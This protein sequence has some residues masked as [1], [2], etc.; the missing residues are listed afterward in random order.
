MCL[1]LGTLLLRTLLAGI[2]PC[3]LPI[4]LLFLFFSA[5]SFPLSLSGVASIEEFQTRLAAY[6]EKNPTIQVVAVVC[7][8]GCCCFVCACLMLSCFSLIFL[9]P[10]SLYS[11]LDCFFLHFYILC[12]SYCSTLLYSVLI[13]N[14]SQLSPPCLR[15]YSV[16]VFVVSHS[17]HTH[18]QTQTDRHIHT[19]TQRETHTDTHTYTYIHTG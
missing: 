14:L 9:L 15:K 7:F 10:F 6:A 4:S 11:F 12:Y 17:T 16:V 2:R 8:L 18:R 5:I 13:H 1:S 3:P 19:D